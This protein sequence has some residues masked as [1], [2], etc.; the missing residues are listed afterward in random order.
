MQRRQERDPLIDEKWARLDEHPLPSPVVREGIAHNLGIVYSSLP[1]FRPLELDLYAQSLPS[2]QVTARPAI[3]WIHGGAF[4]MGSRRLLPDFLSEQ[5]FFRRLANAGFV[6]ASI[7]YRLS[8]EALWP[9]QI[10]DVRA[11]IHWLRSRASELSLDPSAI[12]VWGE[13]AGGN[14]AAMAGVLGSREFDGD[15]RHDFPEVAAVID[16]YGPTDFG[17]MDRQA[18]ADSAMHHDDPQSPESRLLG[19]PVQTVPDLVRAADPATYVDRDTPPMLIRHGRND[20]LVPFGQSVA[21]AAAL[22][23]AGASVR[24][25]PVDDADHVFGGHP[26]PWIFVEE[27]IEFLREVLPARA[28]EGVGNDAA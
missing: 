12:A 8:A 18:P 15:V 6:V 19:A 1:G 25:W 17:A 10:L 27:A 2:V 22:E 23:S 11:A 26:D 28:H 21:L 9:A 13:S 4:A 24:F 5:N 3:V 14:L 20:R 7:D 16:W